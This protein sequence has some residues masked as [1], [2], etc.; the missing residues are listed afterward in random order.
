MDKV[1]K[2]ELDNQAK[3][4]AGEYLEKFGWTILP[5]FNFVIMEEVEINYGEEPRTIEETG[6]YLKQ[7]S[8]FFEIFTT[9]NK[10]AGRGR[11]HK[12]YL[13]ERIQIDIAYYAHYLLWHGDENE[14][15]LSRLQIKNRIHDEWTKDFKEGNATA[16]PVSIKTIENIWKKI[17]PQD[18]TK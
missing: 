11:P 2:Q 7:V 10:K 1:R 6:Y 17:Y 5:I 13:P 8:R 3:K 9:P 15:A 14:M 4:K 16:P 18:W 12:Q